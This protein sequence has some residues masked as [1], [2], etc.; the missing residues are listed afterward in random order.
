MIAQQRRNKAPLS[1]MQSSI[2][3]TIL[4]NRPFRALVGLAAGVVLIS[5]AA[6]VA[7][8][9][10]GPPPPR[11]DMAEKWHEH[12]REHMQA[13]IKALHDLLQIHP[14]QEAAFQT[15]IA[16]MK[17]PEGAEPGAEEGGHEDKAQLTAPQMLDHMAARMAE[18]QRRFEQHAQAVKTFYAVLS[19]EQQRAFDAM[20]RLHHLHGEHGFGGMG[21]HGPMGPHGMGGPGDM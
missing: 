18:H 5:S 3:R 10:Q 12:M 19:P 20:A 14:N 9:E 2:A 13:H 7:A 16:S 11:G 6:V 15:F 21:E 8:Q 1:R 4:M 17:P